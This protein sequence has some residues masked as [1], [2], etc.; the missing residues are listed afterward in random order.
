MGA[1]ARQLYDRQYSTS[2]IYSGLARHLR[3]VARVGVSPLTE[4]TNA[5]PILAREGTQ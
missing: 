1:R 3:D 5:R 2:A 4:V